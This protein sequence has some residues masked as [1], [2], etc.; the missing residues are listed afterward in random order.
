[1]GKYK[2]VE[3]F[4]SINGEAKKAGELAC[5][6][7]FAGCN[8]NCSYCDTKWANAKDA[9]YTEMSAEEIYQYIKSTGS[10][11]CTLTGGEPLLQENIR[12]LLELLSEDR[13]L[14][15]EIETNGSVDLRPF[16]DID[17]P[18]SFTM[19]Y[20]LAGSGMEE[21]MF[22]QNFDILTEKDTVKFVVS[23]VEDLEK[24]KDIIEKYNLTKKCG[25]Y[26]SPVFGKIEPVTMVEFLI[27][28]K[29]N[30]VNIQLQLHKIIWSPDTKGV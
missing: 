17:N 16:A 11:N 10:K 28:N 12:E 20:K 6:I 25:V 19:D 3:K 15:V 2:V 5:F 4:V 22:L 24:S 27:N 18:P 30:D 14:R 1:M 13:E 29:M 7:R 21:T 23:S 26:L 8:L 9:S